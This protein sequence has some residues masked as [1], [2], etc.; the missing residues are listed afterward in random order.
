MHILQSILNELKKEFTWSRKGK[1]R[2]SWFVYTL[3]A[4]IVPFASS[5][6]SNLLRA[7]EIIFGFS[8]IKKKRYYTFMASPKIPWKGLW[9]RI[10][11]MI[12]DAQTN[13]RLLIALDDFINPKTGK[14]IFGCARVFDHAAKVNQ[15]KYP[16]AQNVVAIGLLKMIKGRWACLPLAHRFYHLKKEI[17]RNA[18]VYN[19]K[20][21]GF[22][23]KHAQAVSMITDVAGEFPDANILVVADSWFGNNGMWEP[24]YKELGTQIHMIS[25]LR[26]NN[27]LFAVQPKMDTIRKPGRPRIYGDK[28]GSTSFLAGESRDLAQ[29]YKVNLYGQSRSV[30]AYD[31]VVMLK[32]LK[33]TVRVVWIYRKTRWIALFSTDLTLSVTEIIEYYG[34]RWKIESCFKELK[35]DIGSAETQTRNSVAVTNHLEFCMMATSLTWIY[36]RRLA[37]TPSRR[38]AV[39]GRDHFAFSDVRRLLTRAALDDNFALLC[40]PPGK[41]IYN[42][43]VAALLRLAA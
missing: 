12:P 7:L 37:N 29:E 32:T 31:Q 23:S 20:P 5:K 10:W 15:S 25:R 6:T 18:P 22:Q 42:S 33:R 17:L 28:L 39:H 38:H 35:R 4:I 14:K 3:L 26:S 27:N 11:H 2:G 41:P 43:F 19:G 40:P 16:W 36:A 9:S 34:A 8:G 21:I 13:G 30:L 24:L 1:E